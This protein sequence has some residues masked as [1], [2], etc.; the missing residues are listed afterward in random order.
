MLNSSKASALLRPDIAKTSFVGAVRFQP[1]AARSGDAGG[2]T[3]WRNS[4]NGEDALLQRDAS[5][6]RR[7][8]VVVKIPMQI[9]SP[10][11]SLF[12][13]PSAAARAMSKRS[14]T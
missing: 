4:G 8:G 2:R 5:A 9:C 6:A 7:H 3:N 12:G 10:P 13:S 11:E 1:G 14:G